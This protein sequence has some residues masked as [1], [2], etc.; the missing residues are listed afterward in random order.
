MPNIIKYDTATNII[1]KVA[2]EVGLATVA[3][4]YSSQ[5]PIYIQ[6]RTLLGSVG[7]ELLGKYEWENLIGTYQIT[8][9]SVD[10]GI[11]QLPADFDCMIDQTGWAQSYH[12]PL[13]GPYSA[14][15]W[16][17]L[18]NYPAVGIYLGF[19]IE[20]DQFMIWPTPPPEGQIVNFKY[21]KR[22]FVQD[23]VTPTVFKDHID[24]GTDILLFDW[25]LV[26]KLLKV[27][28]LEAKQFDTTAAANQFNEAW[29]SRVGKNLGAA[30]P[31]DLARSARFPYINGYNVPDLGYG[32]PAPPGG[33]YR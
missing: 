21:M 19:R 14:Q 6:L 25:L 8:T 17:Q 29:D 32:A 5:D 30:A 23:G 31:L 28:F 26:V 12:W 16:Q 22:G 4:P 7:I 10:S 15:V 1:N 20:G 27:R 11:Y 3:D 18:V 24:Q 33:G 2:P 9:H 13:R